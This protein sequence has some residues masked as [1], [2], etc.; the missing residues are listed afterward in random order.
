[1]NDKQVMKLAKKCIKE[2]LSYSRVARKYGIGIGRLK[3]FIDAI[4]RD[5]NVSFCK[6]KQVVDTFNTIEI[7][8]ENGDTYEINFNKPM[9]AVRR[10]GDVI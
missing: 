2:N 9:V 7:I 10:K 3:S 8:F 6:E 1:M 4:K 5:A